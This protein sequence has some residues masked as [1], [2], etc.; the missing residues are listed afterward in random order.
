VVE[1][2]VHIDGVEDD[3][4]IDAWAWSELAIVDDWRG[5]LKAAL[6]GS[7]D[8]RLRHSTHAGL[9]FGDAAS[10]ARWNVASAATS[11]VSLPD[12]LLSRVGQPWRRVRS[13]RGLSPISP[14][15]FIRRVGSVPLRG[16]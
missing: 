16:H 5:V 4:T 1:R 3:G 7:D 8:E 13:V 14:I 9:P 15:R 6:H 2:R 11:A 12:R 10:S